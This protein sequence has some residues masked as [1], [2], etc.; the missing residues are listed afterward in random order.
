MNR[1]IFFRVVRCY[2]KT[3]KRAPSSHQVSQK[4]LRFLY[5]P[6]RHSHC[7]GSKVLRM[8]LS[9]QVYTVLGEGS[10]IEGQKQKG[11]ISSPQGIS[12]LSLSQGGLKCKKTQKAA[13]TSS[14]STLCIS[15]LFAVQ[16]LTIPCYIPRAWLAAAAGHRST[17]SQAPK[18]GK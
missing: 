1:G 15:Q 4:R 14:F 5:P 10:G 6:E 18:K 3:R 13:A 7:L 17:M 8:H 12:M 2:V 11:Q 16:L 9:A